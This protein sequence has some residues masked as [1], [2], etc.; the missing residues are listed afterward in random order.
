MT[1]IML[2]SFLKHS[3]LDNVKCVT[4]LGILPLIDC[5]NLLPKDKYFTELGIQSFI[6]LLKCAPNVKPF[7]ELGIQPFIG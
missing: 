2:L 4:E 3:K 5:L 6:G 1:L 7:T